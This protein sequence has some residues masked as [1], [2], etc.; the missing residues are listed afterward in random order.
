MDRK[1]LIA[2]LCVFVLLVIVLVG[3][4]PT[5]NTNAQPTSP[6][7]SLEITLPHSGEVILLH[8]VDGSSDR[9]TSSSKAELNNPNRTISYER[10]WSKFGDGYTLH[11]TD[12][13]MEY[14][15]EMRRPGSSPPRSTTFKCLRGI[16]D[17]FLN[18]VRFGDE[19]SKVNCPGTFFVNLC[20]SNGTYRQIYTNESSSYP[21]TQE[22][23]FQSKNM[24]GNEFI[25]AQE[26]YNQKNNASISIVLSQSDMRELSGWRSVCKYPYEVY[27]GGENFDPFN[28]DRVTNESNFLGVGKINPEIF[29][30]AGD[31]C[32]ER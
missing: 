24:D 15:V 7:G 19:Y 21:E 6:S 4:Q 9:Y 20:F 13:N 17:D 2:A 11:Y 10:S 27:T 30:T 1:I 29:E 8:V 12:A 22:R 26:E 28:H 14:E 23:L 25:R 5:N 31:G 32:P 16:C 3:F 18:R